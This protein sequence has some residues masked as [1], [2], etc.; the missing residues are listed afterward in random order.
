MDSAGGSPDFGKTR[1]TPIHSGTRLLR[2]VMQIR[3]G[4]VT[5]DAHFFLLS[6]DRRTKLMLPTAALRPVISKARHLIAAK[7]TAEVWRSLKENGERIWLLDPPRQVLDHPAVDTYLELSAENGGCHR[8]RF[9][10]ARDPWY[11]TPLPQRVDGFVSGMS[12]IG[13]WIALKAMPRLAATNTLYVVRFSGKITTDE[14]A[15]WALSMLTSEVRQRLKAVGRVYPD[16]LLKLEPND[17]GSLPLPVPPRIEGAAD[18]YAEAVKALL[19][20]SPEESA[21]MADA[22][23]GDD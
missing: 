8:D 10:L 5:G 21:R 14:K 19:S 7:I 15:A 16:G 11:R 3:L 1:L 18:Y 13:P 6:E 17:L 9:K 20:D 2:D 4:G 22:W 23:F 12:H